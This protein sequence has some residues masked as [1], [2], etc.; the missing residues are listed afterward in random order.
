[1][2]FKLFITLIVCLLPICAN[3]EWTTKD[4]EL[5]AIYNTL[6]VYDWKQTLKMPSK[7]NYTENNFVIAKFYEKQKNLKAARIYY[8]EVADNYADTSWGPKALAKL[9]MIGE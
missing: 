7:K 1:M 4:T 6:Q 9:K 8:K 3:A 2:Y 5:Q